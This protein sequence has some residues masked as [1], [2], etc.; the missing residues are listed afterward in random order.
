MKRTHGLSISVAAVSLYLFAVGVWLVLS[1]SIRVEGVGKLIGRLFRSPYTG[2]LQDFR[3]D[4]GH[5]WVASVSPDLLS[6]KEGAS[7]LM[8]FEDDRQL[9]PAHSAYKDIRRN[10]GG[11]FTHWGPEVY[12]STT[13]HSDPRTNGRRYHAKEESK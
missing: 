1:R 12:F 11:R 6:D 4:E 13:D 9:G 10:G 5:C 7:R 8:V 2:E 3:R